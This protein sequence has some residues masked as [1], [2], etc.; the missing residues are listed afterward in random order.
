MTTDAAPPDS[1]KD[2]NHERMIDVGL[3]E[4]EILIAHAAKV[5]KEVKPEILTVLVNA[6]FAYEQGQWGEEQEVAFWQ[7]YNDICSLVKPVSVDSLKAVTPTFDEKGKM[8]RSKAEQ[9]VYQFRVFTIVVLFVLVIAQVYWLVGSV[10]QKQ[11]HT[12][13]EEKEKIK[14]QIRLKVEL[15][16][17]ISAAGG[18]LSSVQSNDTESSRLETA[19]ATVQQQQDANYEIIVA[20]NRIWQTL[21]LKTEYVGKIRE[22]RK[23]E[24][25]DRRE[26]I[27]SE[28]EK[29]RGDPSIPEEDL[30][31]L[32]DQLK[33]VNL[34]EAQAITRNRLFLNEYSAS[35]M[36]QILQFYVLPLLFGLLG[37]LLYVLRTLSREIGSL[38]YARKSIINYRL[39]ITMG[40]LAGLAIGWFFTPIQGSAK[41]ILPTLSLAF[42][43]GYNVEILFTLMDR[44][45]SKIVGENEKKSSTSDTQPQ[46]TG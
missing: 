31:V 29:F 30:W 15:K 45:I 8:Q 12:L 35:F 40:T 26:R 38:T 14:A 6:Q 33:E 11:L 10:A 17:Q 9:A 42:L 4:A 18:E 1:M 34:N 27:Q 44:A 16:A 2:P 22:Y 13:F 20:W 32:E 19:L 37:S 21:L 5:G 36:I 3:A 43:A 41:E 46:A 25:E 23:K 28:L 7:A 24:F 39:R